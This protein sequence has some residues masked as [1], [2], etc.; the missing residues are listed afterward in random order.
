MDSA[1]RV[2]DPDVACC[3]LDFFD[4]FGQFLDLFPLVINIVVEGIFIGVH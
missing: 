3:E 1:F 2:Q 4:I